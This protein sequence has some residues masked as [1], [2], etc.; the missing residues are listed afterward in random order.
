MGD[1]NSFRLIQSIVE[2]VI[3]LDFTDFFAIAAGSTLI[4]DITRFESD[5][6]FVIARR[7]GDFA[8]F[9]QGQ[10]PYVRILSDPLEIDFYAAG[11]RAQ[12]RKILMHC[13]YPSA[14]T[15]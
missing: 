14:D 9:G 3:A 7:S 4:I 11:R 13:R 10:D 8:D 15:W 1:I 5:L 6:H 12:F 2:F